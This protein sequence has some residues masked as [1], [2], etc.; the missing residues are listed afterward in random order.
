MPVTLTDD[1]WPSYMSYGLGFYEFFLLCEDIDSLAVPVLNCGLSH[2]DGAEPGTRAFDKY[3]DDLL[4][5][6][7]FCRGG[8]DTTWGAVR[9]AMG[10]EEPFELHYIGVGNEQVGDDYYRRYEAFV[11]AFEKAKKKNPDLYDGIEL[12][13]S[14]GFDDGD[15]GT[16]YIESY[17]EAQR[18]LDANP[19]KTLSDFTAAT[20][21]HYY[22]TPDWFYEHTNYYDPENY[23]RDSLTD[24]VFGGRIPVFLG[25]YAAQSNKWNAALAEAAYMTGLERNG[26]IVVM[27]AYAPLFGNATAN[28]WTPDLIWY[29]NHTSQG[30]A[31]YYVQSVFSNN[32]GTKLL[33]T[34]FT[35]D[36]GDANTALTGKV[37]VGTWNT[38]AYFDNVKIVDNKTGEVLGEQ[39]FETDTFD[40]D[41]ERVSDGSW[42]VRQGRLIQS[43]RSTN[44]D[45]YF[46]TG[47]AVYFGDEK[48]TDYTFTVEATKTGGD[49]GFL[50]PFA[51]GDKDNNYFWNIGGW[52]NSV[53]T[54]QRVSG[55]V[56]SDAIAVTSKPIHINNGQTYQLKVVVSGN[57][58]KCY[59]DDELYIDFNASAEKK[60]DVY[61]VVSTDETGD[62]II[63]LVNV[64]SS[65]KTVAID[66]KN[67][68]VTGN[69]HVEIVKGSNLDAENIV[70]E[71]EQVT[72]KSM[73]A[74]G[75]KNQF[76]LTLQ[77]YSVTVIRIKR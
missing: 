71:S 14:S 64:T 41:W 28:H 4:D 61:Q 51:V 42:A 18:W 34:T 10:H 77:K 26:D 52:S 72:L 63:K 30:S 74:G 17:I 49:E 62:I 44:F 55:G 16:T 68:D 13:Y 47:S 2:S 20:D 65:S 48:W 23:S 39:D 46:N 24:T 56:K 15:S 60:A 21:H 19:S 54:L 45:K 6:V 38:A 1:P 9:I 53:S 66:L 35:G 69:A 25:E 37:G 75:F 36:D 27:A 11:D 7:E 58:V 43:S 40:S 73:D 12:M 67:A 50:I 59:I 3:V 31:D 33:G 57:N 22:N 70:G 76:N 8:S 5:L 29:N 32:A